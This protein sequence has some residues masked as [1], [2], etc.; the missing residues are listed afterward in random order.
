MY[1]IISEYPVPSGFDRFYFGSLSAGIVGSCNGLLCIP[2]YKGDC[3][4]V[5]YLY[6]P[7]IRKFKRLPD[8]SFSE[9]YDWVAAGFGY[10]S[11][12][13]DYKVIRIYCLGGFTKFGKPKIKCQYAE[14]YTLSSNSWRRVEI[15]LRP[16]VRLHGNESISHATFAREALHWLVDFIEYEDE[17][18]CETKILSFDVYNEKSRDIALPDGGRTTQHIA[19]PDGCRTQ[20]IAVFRGKLAFITVNT[21]NYYDPY[22]TMWVMEEYGDV[23]ESWNKLF[24]LLIKTDFFYGCTRYAGLPDALQGNFTYVESLVLLDGGTE[25]SG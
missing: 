21:V 20:H 14:V 19:L 25:L 18:Q 23:H 9:R 16:N 13:N 8:S 22:I 11:K 5:I 24:S 3:V 1:D 15:S 4:D 7:V 10:Q 17:L 6:N 12:T 2:H